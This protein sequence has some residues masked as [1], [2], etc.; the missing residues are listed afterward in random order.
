M[1]DYSTNLNVIYLLNTLF[2]YYYWIKLIKYPKSHVHDIWNKYII[3]MIYRNF[4]HYFP[5]F[6]DEKYFNFSEQSN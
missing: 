6:N 3:T 2:F 4:Y 1:S 5:L